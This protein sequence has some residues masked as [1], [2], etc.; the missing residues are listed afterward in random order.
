VRLVFP[1]KLRKPGTDQQTEQRRGHQ[2]RI[3]DKLFWCYLAHAVV[4]SGVPRAEIG[5]HSEYFLDRRGSGWTAVRVVQ[6]LESCA[7]RSV[8]RCRSMSQ[9]S[10]VVQLQPKPSASSWLRLISAFSL[11]SQG[12]SRPTSSLPQA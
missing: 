1:L 8:F 3:P 7:R 5:A 10:Q 2:D 12:S 9:Y 11:S 6:R 4:A